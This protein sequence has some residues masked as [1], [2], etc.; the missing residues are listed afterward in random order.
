MGH[1]SA[2]WLEAEATLLSPVTDDH[3]TR[4]CPARIQPIFSG[5]GVRSVAPKP[6]AKALAA[7]LET[8]KESAHPEGCW[9][10]RYSS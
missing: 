10:R 5:E 8:R 1:R 3:F 2:A 7:P 6:L 9:H 4:D